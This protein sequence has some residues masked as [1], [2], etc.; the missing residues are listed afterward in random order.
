M[1][2]RKWPRICANRSEAG[3]PNRLS[4]TLTSG[5]GSGDD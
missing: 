5:K 2:Q 3:I 1:H 4:K